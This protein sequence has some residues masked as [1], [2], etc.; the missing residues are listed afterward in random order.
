[1][2]TEVQ[3]RDDQQ[4]NLIVE[5][6]SNE[7]KTYTIRAAREIS[8][9]TRIPGFRPGKAPFDV[10]KKLFGEEHIEEK[11]IQILLDEVYPK[12]LEQEKI[13]PSGPG[14]IEEMP[15]LHPPFIKFIVP[16]KPEVIL[17]DYRSIRKDYVEPVVTDEQVE[18]L[19]KLLQ[20]DNATSE[21]VTDRPAQENDRVYITL[22]GK[23]IGES[24]DNE[25]VKNQSLQVVLSEIAE[26]EGNPWPFLGFYKE[27]I[28]MKLDEEKEINYIYP[29]DSVYQDLRGKEVNFKFQVH[30]INALTLPELND[31]FA[32][33]ISNESE[34]LENLR[35]AIR[36][37]LSEK[38][39]SEYENKYLRELIDDIV[40]Q[41]I[42]KYPPHYLEHQIEETQE[43]IETNLRRQR[44][45]LETYLKT[46]K[47][48]KETFIEEEVKPTAKRQLE[49]SLVLQKLIEVEEIKVTPNEISTAVTATIQRMSYQKMPKLPKGMTTKDFISETAFRTTNYMINERLMHRLK[50]IASGEADKTATVEQV[51]EDTSPNQEAA[52]GNESQFEQE[53]E[54]SPTET[55]QSS[56]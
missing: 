8:K 20:Y 4:V 23:I 36:D 52:S 32:Q 35:N 12:A 33:T 19:L 24:E 46:I 29:E 28:G 7:V 21:P 25:L 49:R 10:V 55:T 41:S 13:D 47:K 51:G 22:N 40:N 6:D 42:I 50:S 54:S 30:G 39:K 18:K 11:A 37:S 38:H 31:E 14:R 53:N 27:I 2:K 45:D 26:T 34:T 48:D 17:P 44:M 43:E 5:L 15:T 1:M 56:E 16:L 9:E 3:P